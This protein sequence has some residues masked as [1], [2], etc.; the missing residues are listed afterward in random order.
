MKIHFW[1]M[2]AC[3]NDFLVVDSVRE[4]GVG[5]LNSHQVA[6]ICDRNFGVGADGLVVLHG[7]TSTNARWEF[8]NADGSEAEMCGNAARCSI[9]F[10]ADRYF[11]NERVISLMTAA[12]VVKGKKLGPGLAEVSVVARS[13]PELR[14][15]DRVTV[16]DG[17]GTVRAHFID[18]GVPHAVIEVD[19]IE[20]YPIVQVGRALRF[21]PI[22]GP[23][24]ANVTF[25]QK[26]AGNAIY[27]TTYERGVENETLSC[28]TGAVAAANI[29]SETY[30]QSLP[31]TVRVPGGELVVDMSPVSRVVLLRGP[32]NYVFDGEF[33]MGDRPY[34][35]VHLYSHSRQL[36]YEK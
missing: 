33:P 19:S 14:Y 32:A 21:N 27:C 16:V 17:V 30:L 7:G 18:T 22:F 35:K 4:R 28:G 5:A 2:E 9:L 12:G 3:G 26:T 20:T 25:F 8:F 31:I 15:E 11:A 24:G 1:K 34:K 36:K 23:K 6:Q 29:F 10:L 13:N